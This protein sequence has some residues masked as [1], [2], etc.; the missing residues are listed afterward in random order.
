MRCYAIRDSDCK[1]T[2]GEKVK[3]IRKIAQ[4]ALWREDWGKMRAYIFSYKNILL[5]Y[6]KTVEWSKKKVIWTVITISRLKD[7]WANFL[8]KPIFE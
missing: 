4:N 2:V 5:K 1:S 3:Y 8:E 6:T 7:V